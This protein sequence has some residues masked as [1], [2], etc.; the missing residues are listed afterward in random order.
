[1]KKTTSYL[2]ILLVA[3]GTA[4]CSGS[5]SYYKK[6]QNLEK[7]GLQIEA[8]NFYIE[9]LRRKRTNEDAIIALKSLGQKVLD[10]KYGMFYKYYSD[11]DHRDAVYAYLDAE[12][13]KSKVSAVGVQLTSAPYYKDYYEESRDNYIAELYTKAQRSLD[14]EAFTDAEKVLNEIKKLDPSY[15]NVSALSDFAFLE[16]KYRQALRAYD[17]A[18]FRKAFALFKEINDRVDA[19][20]KESKAY[21]QL[22]LESAQYTIGILPIE[23]RS[24]INNFESG[25]SGSIIRE[26]QRLNDPFLKLVDRSHTDQILEEQYYNMNGAVDRNTAIETGTMLGTNAI[27]VGKLISA[28]KNTGQLRKSS[29]TGWLGK[30]VPFIDPAT[31]TK[32]VRIVYTKVYYYE[33]EQ[34]NT[35]TCTFQYQLISTATGE[36]LL[37]DIVEIKEND[38]INYATFNG[39]SRL[40]ID[41]Y[42]RNQYKE[43]AS[44]RRY[45][46]Y[47]QKSELDKKLKADRQITDVETLANQVFSRVGRSVAAAIGKFNPE[48]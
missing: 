9:A 4:A 10:E 35:V 44:D 19:G 22:A 46:S 17:A 14:E 1:M 27:F 20:Y 25:I 47:S 34:E 2:I 3:F 39:D 37:S 41:G 24:G 8:A 48:T 12:E 16:P 28:N 30:E 5:K 40:L 11:D 15:K 33:Y 38:Y 18:E 21:M 45:D 31:G 6:G 29:R 36:V 43:E 26:I 23:N 32:K 42:W 13:F 7:S